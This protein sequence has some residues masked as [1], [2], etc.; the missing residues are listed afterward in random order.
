MN[1][2]NKTMVIDWGN[3][4]V[5]NHYIPIELLDNED[6]SQEVAIEV[7]EKMRPEQSNTISSV[8]SKLYDIYNQSN[9]ES[10]NETNDDEDII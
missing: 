6:I 9:T 1:E 5:L 7:I 4:V 3:G 8:S 10:Y 2:E